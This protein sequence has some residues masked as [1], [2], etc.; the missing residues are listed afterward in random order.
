MNSKMGSPNLISAN[1]TAL[2]SRLLVQLDFARRRLGGYPIFDKS[3]VERVNLNRLWFFA[4]SS[5]VYGFARM[6][7]SFGCKP[8]LNCQ[9]GE[10]LD[11]RGRALLGFI[12]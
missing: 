9:L 12:R 6:L 2:A 11:T 5:R 3:F 1:F 7:S 10:L 4:E 8:A